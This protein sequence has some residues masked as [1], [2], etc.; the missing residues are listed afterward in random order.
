MASEPSKTAQLLAV[1]LLLTR[2]VS[3]TCIYLKKHII[4][5]VVVLAVPS[6]MG[7]VRLL[8]GGM[9]T[10]GLTV[11][12]I[13]S[14]L[15]QIGCLLMVAAETAEDEDMRRAGLPTWG[16]NRRRDLLQ[17][18]S[19]INIVI[20]LVGTQLNNSYYMAGSKGGDIITTSLLCAMLPMVLCVLV[21]YKTKVI[22]LVLATLLTLFSL[23]CFPFYLHMGAGSNSFFFWTNNLMFGTNLSGVG[24]LIYIAALGA[25]RY[26]VDHMKQQ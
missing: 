8:T 14:F 23:Y 18:L 4:L 19:R 26:S 6:F 15:S 25:G 24:S 2:V 12:F 10:T 9:S 1:L 22:S 16:V 11:L 3:L 13:S 5:S 17:L 21:G 20:V 7:A